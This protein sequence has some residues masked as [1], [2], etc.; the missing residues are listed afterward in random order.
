MSNTG[1]KKSPVGKGRVPGEKKNNHRPNYRF[2]R[3]ALGKRRG[4]TR[5][6]EGKAGEHAER[7]LT[8]NQFAVPTPIKSM[9]RI[10]LLGK[11]IFTRFIL[12]EHRSRKY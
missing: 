5:Q 12:R 11:Y 6:G 7:P 4:E 10:R 1:G 9:A 3:R 8:E 2:G